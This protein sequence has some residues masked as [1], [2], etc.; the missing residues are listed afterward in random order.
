VECLSIKDVSAY[1]GLHFLVGY[2]YRPLVTFPGGNG[3][4]VER[5][6]Q[7]LSDAGKCEF[8]T[9]SYVYSVTQT[10]SGV[11]ICFQNGGKRYCAN[12]DALI[13]AGAKYTAVPVIEGLQQP[14]KDAIGQIEHRDYSIAGV[15]LKKAVLNGYFGGYV[16]EGEISGKYPNS[17]CRS[18]VCLAA[19]WI[20]PSY[21]RDLGVLTLLKPIS[22]AADQ[23]KLDQANFRSLQKTAYGEVRDMLIAVGASPDLIE[24]I[25]LWRW[26]N[27]LVVSKVGQMK[28]DV[29]ERASQPSGAIFF[30][31]Q[32]SVGVGNMESAIWAGSNAA[33]QVFDYLQSHAAE[34]AL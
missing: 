18:G 14:Q 9:G 15:Y 17:W 11:K 25:K 24:D 34:P 21:S 6:H 29:F 19:N 28:N 33:T 12:A 2:L 26:P 27:G 5:I 8:K 30:A 10:E 13:W 4:I 7:R 16:I 22:G 3:H 31:N 20:D 32:D 1:V 23:G